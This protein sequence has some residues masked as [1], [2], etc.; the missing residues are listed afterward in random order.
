MAVLTMEVLGRHARAGAGIRD[1]VPPA[2]QPRAGAGHVS[3]DVAGVVSDVSVLCPRA[4]AIQGNAPSSGAHGHQPPAR[5]MEPE[6][7]G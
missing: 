6:S 1:T 2:N 7:R 3:R 4:D 5:S